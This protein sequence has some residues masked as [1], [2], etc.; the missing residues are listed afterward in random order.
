MA[1]LS[2]S[3][4]GVVLAA[5]DVLD[6]HEANSVF[7]CQGLFDHAAERI[8]SADLAR[9]IHRQNRVMVRFA[10]SVRLG[11]RGRAA[12]RTLR[13]MAFFGGVNKI[14]F[15]RSKSKV[16]KTR[17][18]P[19]SD[20]IRSWFIVSDA[21]PH[22]ARMQHDLA[23][24][25]RLAAGLFIGNNVRLLIANS[26]VAIGEH[27]ETRPTLPV[28]SMSCRQRAVSTCTSFEALN[29]R[30][31]LMAGRR[32]GLTTKTGLTGSKAKEGN[33]AAFTDAGDGTLVAHRK[34]PLSVSRDGAVSTSAVPFILSR[35]ALHVQGWRWL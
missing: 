17:Q 19:P 14:V 10:A 33:A 1:G 24:W 29:Q 32:T 2:R 31:A 27:R 26:H 9:L 22:V 16:P 18:N 35:P 11:F 30:W 23:G 12:V 28:F 25:N 8:T 21:V 7:D 20:S 5:Q 4:F 15:V 34:L 6:R 13:T 3:G